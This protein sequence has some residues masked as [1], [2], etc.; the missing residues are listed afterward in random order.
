MGRCAR[1]IVPGS[2]SGNDHADHQPGGPRPAPGVADPGL[3]LSGNLTHF[4]YDTAEGMV[5]VRYDGALATAGG[6]RVETRRFE[7]KIP[8]DGTARTVGPALNAAANQV[9]NE[10]AQWIGR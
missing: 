8:A 7:A 6:T 3:K 10:V 1:Q 5:I 2:A 9:A 4:G